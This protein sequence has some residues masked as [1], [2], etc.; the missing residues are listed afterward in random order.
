L[1]RTESDTLSR[2]LDKFGA[3]YRLKF[4]V[5]AGDPAHSRQKD[6]W[7]TLLSSRHDV[8]HGAGST[9]TY[10][11]V[12]SLYREAFTVLEYFEHCLQLS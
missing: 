10:E 1:A 2:H 5:W 9:L 7:D 11:E 8:A 12:E 6:A 4:S 3:Q